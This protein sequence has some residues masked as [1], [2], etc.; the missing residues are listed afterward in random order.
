MICL[1]AIPR[2]TN[3]HSD[4]Q[5]EEIM[6]LSQEGKLHPLF[7]DIQKNNARWAATKMVASIVSQLI[8]TVPC[9]I[10][11]EPI[12]QSESV[13]NKKNQGHVFLSLPVLHGIFYKENIM[14]HSDQEHG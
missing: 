6:G 4:A 7:R 1:D 13:C 9:H 8:F 11:S 14:M 10:V 5:R 3:R 12:H 2:V